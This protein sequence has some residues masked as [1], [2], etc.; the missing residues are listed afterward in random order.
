MNMLE[1]ITHRIEGLTAV[2]RVAS[3]VADAVA[4]I[5]HR[6]VAAEALAGTPLGHPLHPLLTDLPIGSWTSAFFLD[7][8]GGRAARPASQTLIGIGVLTAV[9]TA[10]TGLADWS[11][12]VGG[13]RRIGAVHATV[14]SV[15][16]GLYALSW[17]RRRRGHH[18]NGVMLSMLGASVAT[19]G[20]YLGGHLVYRTGTGVDV[21][22][23]RSDPEDWTSAATAQPRAE[24]QAEYLVADGTE[25]L[26][27]RDDGRWT[28]IGARCS[29]RGGPLQDGT[30]EDGCVTCPWHGS[31]F[32]LDDGAV[33]A[34]PATAPQP[35]YAVREDDG[36]FQVR[37]LEAGAG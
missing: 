8:I 14:N 34:G 24:G 22:A 6:P 4:N 9:P 37:P 25:V 19:F 32:R 23:P 36:T 2:D 27:S 28:G 5:A 1:E 26:A 30:I 16:L 29:H 7:L 21:N 13:T 3:R 33:V 15:A 12:T 10:L 18:L 17:A 31:R 20:A 11:D 35:R